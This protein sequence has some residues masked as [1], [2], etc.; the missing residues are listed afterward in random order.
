MGVVPSRQ[1]ARPGSA[2]LRA[3]LADRPLVWFR[4]G[5]GSGSA[6][7]STGKT[8]PGTVNGSPLRAQPG[9]IANDN[10]G[11]ISLPGNA[12]PSWIVAN[13]DLQRL[14]GLTVEAWIKPGSIG[15]FNYPEFVS[16]DAYPFGF[17]FGVS[18]DSQ[19]VYFQLADGAAAQIEVDSKPIPWDSTDWTYVT[20]TWDGTTIT[21]WINGRV[22][23]QKATTITTLNVNNHFVNIGRNPTNP[24]GTYFLGYVD[25]VSIYDHALLPARIWQHYVAGVVTPKPANGGSGRLF[26]AMAG[27]DAYLARLTSAQRQTVARR[28][29]H[30]LSSVG[31]YAPGPE[32]PTTISMIHDLKDQNPGLLLTAYGGTY[33]MG[34]IT[35]EGFVT[36]STTDT[37]LVANVSGQLRP[38]QDANNQGRYLFDPGDTSSNAH[39]RRV[40]NDAVSMIKRY[41]L[42]DGRLGC[43]GVFLDNCLPTMFH[44]N[45]FQVD[46]SGNPVARWAISEGGDGNLY[47]PWNPRTQDYYTDIDWNR[48]VVNTAYRVVTAVKSAFPNAIVLFN[49]VFYYASGDTVNGQPGGNPGGPN[50]SYMLTQALTNGCDFE[51]W[52][53]ALWDPL[54]AYNDLYQ[55]SVPKAQQIASLPNKPYT[56]HTSGLTDAAA[57]IPQIYT[58]NKYCYATYLLIAQPGR[59]DYLFWKDPAP[60]SWNLYDP[61]NTVWPGFAFDIGTPTANYVVNGDGSYSRTYSRGIVVTN[62]TGGT[63]TG[64]ALGATYNRT[65]NDDGTVT[66]GAISSVTLAPQTA[67]IIGS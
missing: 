47:R 43:D 10:D 36:D 59:T 64:H 52:V 44:I 20:A 2:W 8:T 28:L 16:S 41:V 30:C 61:T 66:T 50:M 4:L 26:Q 37:R 17:R 63:I 53:H 23:D 1:P 55:W 21:L 45:T 9:A 39:W 32:L 57:T 46:G 49:G 7:D 60:E 40:V 34:S 62:P 67:A 15:A 35:G 29:D 6:L 18:G 51:E 22:Q 19:N 54:A 27:G 58:L 11:S 42:E 25:E 13:A 31:L 38:L 5:E 56:M 12:T 65:L 24:T 48:D 33:D 14:K 3:V